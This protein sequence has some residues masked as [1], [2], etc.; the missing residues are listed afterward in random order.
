MLHSNRMRRGAVAVL[1]AFALTGASCGR[2]S[3]EQE[4]NGDD[5]ET[6]EPGGGGGLDDGTFGD[7]ERICQDGD[8]GGASDVGVTDSSIQIGTV[9]DKGFTSRPG[10]NE[11]MYDAAVAFAAWCNSLG[12]INGREIVVADRDA[13]MLSFNTQIQEACETDFALVGGGAVLDDS[14]NGGR[15]ACGL[16]NFP[17]YVVSAGARS[18]GLQVQ[19]L[20]NPVGNINIG[21]YRIIAQNDPEAIDRMGIVTSSFGSVIDVRDDTVAAAEE[22]GYEVVY[23][24]EYDSL[25]ESNW[26]PF[27]EAMRDAD[28][29]VLDFVGEPT[30]V[31]QLMLA[32][33]EID[34]HPRYIVLNANFYDSLFLETSG[35]IAENTSVRLQFTPLELADENDATADYLALMEEYNPDG[36][37]ALLGMQALSSLLLFAQSASACGAEL[38]R[39]CVLEE[40]GSVTEWTGGGL[41]AAQN[42]AETR[43][44]NCFVSVAMT[45]EAFVVSEELTN[46]NDGI[47][48]CDDANVAALSD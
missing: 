14:D 48:N 16:P 36:K 34:Y 43:P 6:T 9:T 17:G 39:A 13:A 41:H 40:A 1:V 24:E 3:G 8:A 29:Q 35:A 12:G 47:F 26:R 28:V 31:G 33:E 23:S 4:S 18:A 2:D 19:A 5:P 7:L 42:P 11:E 38:T 21:P 10:L 15:E 46:P 45:P 37:V 22:L 25:G 20:P 32:L 44:G 27:A 30:Y